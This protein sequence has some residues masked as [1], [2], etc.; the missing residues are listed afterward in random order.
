MAELTAGQRVRS[1]ER[2]AGTVVRVSP[3]RWIGLVRWDR[4][5]SSQVDGDKVYRLTCEELVREAIDGK[6]RDSCLAR[7][8]ALLAGGGRYLDAAKGVRR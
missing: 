3:N 4:G 6:G 8:E 1:K 2:G 7:V 5:G